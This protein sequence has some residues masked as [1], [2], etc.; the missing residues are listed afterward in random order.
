MNKKRTIRK[1]TQE[2][3]QDAVKLVTE[4]GYA[5]SQVARSLGIN[6]NLI[7][8]WKGLIEAQDG[9][10]ALNK[11]EREELKR[12]RAEN[13][14]LRIEGEILKKASILFAKEIA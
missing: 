12:L 14:R 1:Y 6:P 5:V 13:K 2:F 10:S 8:R 9:E 4:Q 7:Y 3:K 11:S